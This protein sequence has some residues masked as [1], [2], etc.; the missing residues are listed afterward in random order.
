MTTPPHSP[1]SAAFGTWML[2]R[3]QKLQDKHGVTFTRHQPGDTTTPEYPIRWT[4]TWATPDGTSHHKGPA[5]MP[6]LIPH[7]EEELGIRQ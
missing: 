5:T 2:G 7:I 1:H 3:R 4:A 6:E